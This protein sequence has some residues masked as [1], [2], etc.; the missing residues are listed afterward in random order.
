MDWIEPLALE[1]W[2]INVFAG[3][4]EIFFA[5]AMFFIFGIAGYFRMNTLTMFFIFILFLI[6][7]EAYVASYIFIIVAVIG[8][9][10]AGYWISKIVK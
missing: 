2:V 8:G 4:Q 3:S 9:L 5:V 10:L 7:F 6:M 1:T